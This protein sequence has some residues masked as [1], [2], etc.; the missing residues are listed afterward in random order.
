MLAKA[1]FAFCSILARL[2]QRFRRGFTPCLFIGFFRPKLAN[3]FKTRNSF[4]NLDNLLW[5]KVKH[6]LAKLQHPLLVWRVNLDERAATIKMA[7]QRS[8]RDDD[9]RAATITQAVFS[10]SSI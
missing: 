6:Y 7:L 9:C 1:R 10:S 4:A 2:N 8:R 3:F 5:V